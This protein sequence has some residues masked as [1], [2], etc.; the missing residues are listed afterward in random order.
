M[1]IGAT[2]E[3]ASHRDVATAVAVAPAASPWVRG[4]AWDGF[5]M[6]SALWLVPIAAWLSHGYSQPEDSPLDLLYF[7]LTALFWI[8]HRLSSTYLAYCTEAYRPLLRAQPVR[9]VV[10]PLLVTVTC[11]AVLLPPDTALPWSREARL[12]ALAIL[13]YVF[14]T[15]HFA[16]QHFGALSLYRARAGSGAGTGIRTMDRL[17]ALGV[18]GVLVLLADVLAGAVAYQDRWLDRWAVPAWLVSS[19]DA[20]RAG[21][22]G[23]L[24]AATAAM[25]FVELRAPR[26]SWPRVLYVL[27]VAAMVGLALRPRSLFLFLVIWTSQHWILATGLASR[28]PAEE[29]APMRGGVRRVLHGLN[30]RPWAVLLLVVVASVVL[31]PLFEVEGG[32]QGI[33]AQYYGDRIF[34]AIATALR[35]S[36][37][38]PALLALGFAT[39]FVHYLLD[40]SVYRL[41]D[42]QVRVAA[43]GLLARADGTK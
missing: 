9:F 25:L 41:S 37:W 19:Q 2:S 3:A 24:V 22:I 7:G 23:V 4:P 11:F 12:V 30:T 6:L 15:Y 26:W 32:R 29:P 5:W 43:R 31:L 39:G 35:T 21:A 28:A 8:G 34:G 20:I 33:D 10:L 14:V 27:G 1:T 16:A 17:F 36:S 42:P 40:R 18:G 38:V 13:D